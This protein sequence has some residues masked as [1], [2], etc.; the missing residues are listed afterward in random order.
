MSLRTQSCRPVRRRGEFGV[1]APVAA[2]GVEGL[3]QGADLRR[4]ATLGA[5]G[6][7][8]IVANI[9]DQPSDLAGGH[10]QQTFLLPDPFYRIP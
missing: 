2:G 5:A 3:D 9:G 6:A 4:R 1:D 10:S 7:D 8:T